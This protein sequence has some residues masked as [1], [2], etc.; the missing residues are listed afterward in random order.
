MVKNGAQ[1]NKNKLKQLFTILTGAYTWHIKH[2]ILIVSV[3]GGGPW[4]VCAVRV[5]KSRV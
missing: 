3:R 2:Y 1:F 5:S 4:G